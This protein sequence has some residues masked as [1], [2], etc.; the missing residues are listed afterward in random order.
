MGAIN[1]AL[2]QKNQF[3][4]EVAQIK[5]NSGIRDM[6]SYSVNCCLLIGKMPLTED[7]QRSFELFRGNSK[8]VEIVTFNELLEKLK[9]F[10]E[11]LE[12]P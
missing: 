8:D 4:K 11:F 7:R 10:R 12:S 9:Q 1:Q 3:E 2:A 6:A 5:D